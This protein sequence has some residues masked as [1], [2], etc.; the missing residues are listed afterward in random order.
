[1]PEVTLT[2]ASEIVRRDRATVFRWCENNLIPSRRIGIRRDIRIQIDDLRAFAL[3]HGYD[4][5]AALAAKYSQ[6]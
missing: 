3:K 2:Q 6:L 1:M 5:D 4:Y